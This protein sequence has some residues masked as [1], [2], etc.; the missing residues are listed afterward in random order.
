MER[1]KKERVVEELKESFRT[2]QAVFVTDFKG[3]SML[4]I[5][6]LRRKVKASGAQ[7]RVT[8]NT[9]VKLAAAGTPASQ[10]DRYLTGNNAL[11]Y[12]ENDPASL[13]KTLFDFAKDEK[14][15]SVKGGILGEKAID[16]A[17]AKALAALPSREALLSSLLG[18]MQAVPGNFVRVLAAVPRKF[19]YALTAI[20]DQRDHPDGPGQPEQPEQKDAA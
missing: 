20:R 6:G 13:A 1:K 9:L 8:K 19:L 2:S 4:T 17:Q 18:T 14:K 16:A 11:A 15:F 3:L 7:F 5:G 12:T 10:L